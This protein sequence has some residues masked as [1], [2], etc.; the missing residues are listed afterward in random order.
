MVLSFNILHYIVYV[1]LNPLQGFL[2]ELQ[3]QL[4]MLLGD[5]VDVGIPLEKLY[6]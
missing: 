1:H 2:L 6:D 5:V 4:Y 3:Q